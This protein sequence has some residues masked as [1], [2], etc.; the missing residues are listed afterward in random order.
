MRNRQRSTHV[1]VGDESLANAKDT[2]SAEEGECAI[3]KQQRGMSEDRHPLVLRSCLGSGLFDGVEDAEEE[4]D[5]ED[6]KD[7]LTSG[8]QGLCSCESRLLLRRGQ[9]RVGA[10]DC[11]RGAPSGDDESIRCDEELPA[12][13]VMSRLGNNERGT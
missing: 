13:T 2:S 9:V 6:E 11:R 3:E 5:V 8:S 10:V 7:D 12:R 4:D 1:Q